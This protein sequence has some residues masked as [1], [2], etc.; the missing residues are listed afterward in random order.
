V[1]QGYSGN[2]IWQSNTASNNSNLAPYKLELQNEGYISI[3]NGNGTTIWTSDNN[4]PATT[5]TTSTTKASLIPGN[6]KK[7]D[8]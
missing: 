7:K 1:L 4:L 2:I 8:F 3:I 6:L 5:T